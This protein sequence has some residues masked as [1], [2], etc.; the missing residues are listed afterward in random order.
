MIL[1]LTDPSHYTLVLR[2]SHLR[3][4]ENDTFRFSRY[5]QF[6]RSLRASDLPP[7]ESTSAASLLHALSV[8]H[9]NLIQRFLVATNVV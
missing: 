7:R 2:N 3:S 1:V 5:Q 6:S 8:F 4:R 9:R